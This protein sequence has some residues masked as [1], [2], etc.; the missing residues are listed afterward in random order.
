[1]NIFLRNLNQQ[2]NIEMFQK[3]ILQFWRNVEVF[4]LPDLDEKK[5]KP[6]N[7]ES[8]L[9]WLENKIT[10]K[11]KKRIYTL[12]FGKVSK[13]NVVKQ[14]NKIFHNKK[15]NQWKEKISGFTCFSSIVLDGHGQPDPNRYTLASYVFGIDVLQIKKDIVSVYQLL[16]N[17][18]DDYM[19]RFNILKPTDGG[20]LKNEVVSWDF[21]HKEIDYLKQLTDWNTDDIMI[22]Y[23]EKDVGI[24]TEVDTPF[25]NSFYLEDLNKLVD[26][27]TELSPTLQKYLTL[28]PDQIK[29]DLIKNKDELFETI[30]PEYLT[31]GKWVSSPKYGLCTAQLG[32]VNSIF[33][34]LKNHFGIQGI[35]GPPET[36]KTTLLLDIIAQIVVERAKKNI[37]IGVDKIFGNHEKIAEYIHTYQ[38]HPAL[39][40]N[41]GIVVAS[42]NNAAVENISKELPQTKKIDKE[43]FP[44]ADYFGEYAKKELTGEENW[45]M[46]AAALGSSEN[47]NNFINSGN[48]FLRTRTVMKTKLL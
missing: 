21:I 20:N 48:P 2:K 6:L 37:D 19:E 45:G 16:Q 14:I 28:N 10:E 46:L 13:E 44:D 43:T 40:K 42:N 32:A 39:Q 5:L 36:G 15:E 17:V 47:K 8:E 31:E 27:G 3:N 35:N 24:N 34:D 23:I 38:L 18:S 30:N 12:Y 29:S 1:M 26:K 41:Y 11:N 4:I 7:R 22:Y 33:K 25:L 9:P